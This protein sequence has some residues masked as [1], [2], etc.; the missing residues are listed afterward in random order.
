MR[1]VD[2]IISLIFSGV[3]GKD[4][5]LVVEREKTAAGKIAARFIW[6]GTVRFIT[7]QPQLVEYKEKGEELSSKRVFRYR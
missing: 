6:P 7:C 1:L 2:P 5:M 4:G 3:S